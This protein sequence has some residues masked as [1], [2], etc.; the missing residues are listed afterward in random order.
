MI[1]KKLSP[2]LLLALPFVATPGLAWDYGEYAEE[3]VDVLI[4]DYP[5]RYSGTTSYRGA[6]DWMRQRIGSD[7]R[8]QDFEAQGGDAWNVVR[9]LQGSSD[10]K[11]VVGAHYDS[12]YGVPDLEGLDDNASGAGLLTELA[13]NLSGIPMENGIEVIAFGAEEEGLVGSREYVERLSDSERSALI[14]MI[15]ID[16]LITGDHMYANAGSDSVNNP[17]LFALRDRLLAIADELS[18]DLRSNPGLNPSYPT[19]T[20]C[21]SDGESFEDLGIPVIFIESTNWSIGADDGYTQ[22]TNPAIPGGSTWH[23][24]AEDNREVLTN[25]F[26]EERVAERLRLYSLLLTRLLVERSNADLLASARSAAAM[27]RVQA[28]LLANQRS[29]ATRFYDDRFGQLLVSA[30]VAGETEGG[31]GIEGAH[32]PEDGFDVAGE[33]Q[34]KGASFYLWGDRQFEGDVT[35]GVN[36]RFDYRRDDLAHSGKLSSDTWQLGSYALWNDGGAWWLGGNLGAG[37]ADLDARRSVFLQSGNGPVLLDQRIDSDTNATFYGARLMG[38][39]DV[40]SNALRTGPFAAL[41]YGR[42]HIDDYREDDP[43][44]TALNVES[45]RFD[46]LQGSLGWRVQGL[47]DLQ[48]EAALLPRA[49][50]AWVEEWGD[51]R[52]NSLRVTPAADGVTRDVSLPAV[53]EHFGRVEAGVEMRMT[54]NFSVTADATSRFSHDEGSQAGY[55]LGARWRF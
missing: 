5:G 39:Y 9:T 19:G 43:R 16:S 30:P 10:R 13:Q 36:A 1:I 25:A 55:T 22:T 4:D 2:A 17:A 34:R 6:T 11:L 32:Q 3:T 41:D 45:Q 23:D 7:T 18:I 24:P 28:D 35:L 50:L 48:G 27:A 49:S 44:R 53:D 47:L 8:L 29:A 26:G 51:G 52:E 21:C 12:A 31:F 33:Q 40:V 14:G 46:S 20:G 38:G 54:S 15:N 42:Y 37:Y